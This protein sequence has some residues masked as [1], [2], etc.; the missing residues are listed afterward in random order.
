LMIGVTLT[1]PDAKRVQTEAR[2]RG[3][4]LNAIGDDILRFLPP[5]II[6]QGDVDEAMSVL[7][8]VL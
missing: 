1:A 5:L 3:L 4:I 6:T 8:S 2:E 7:L